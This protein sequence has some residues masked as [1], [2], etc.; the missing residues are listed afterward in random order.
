MN[1]TGNQK[2]QGQKSFILVEKTHNLEMKWKLI[3][4]SNVHI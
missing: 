3:N 2:H 4:K 1:N